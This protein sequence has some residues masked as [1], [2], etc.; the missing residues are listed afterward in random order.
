M[1][2]ALVLLGQSGVGKDA[3]ANALCRDNDG[4]VNTKF[5]VIAKHLLADCLCLS[6]ADM[7][8]KK[9]REAYTFNV[10]GYR[11]ELTLL[12]LLDVMFQGC[13]GTALERDKFN[14]ALHRIGDKTPVFTDVRSL[15]EVDFIQ[16][17]YN[18]LVIRIY[19]DHI[20]T[21]I[22]DQQLDAVTSKLAWSRPCFQ[23]I[24]HTDALFSNTL[25]SVKRII[26]LTTGISGYEVKIPP[27]PRNRTNEV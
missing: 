27:A 4:L 11:T 18:A 9:A 26:D 6:D 23:V 5:A 22:S 14:Y 12:G 15:A 21:G 8:N 7:E 1:Y 13:E 3:I 24:R 16:K 19:A 20:P 17:H 25:A 10:R 2:N